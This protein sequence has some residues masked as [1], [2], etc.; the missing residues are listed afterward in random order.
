[1]PWCKIRII[2][3]TDLSAYPGWCKAVLIDYY[4]K[5]H[6]IIEKLPVCGVDY[7]ESLC[8][9]CDGYIRCSILNEHADFI[10]ISTRTPDFIE[11]TDGI[12]RFTVNKALISHISDHYS[13]F[14]PTKLDEINIFNDNVDVCVTTDD[15]R[16]YTF[17][18]ATKENL[19]QYPDLIALIVEKLTIENITACIDSIMR[20]DLQ[21]IEHYGT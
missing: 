13:L 20:N 2:E 19:K 7:S 9:P 5:E 3:Y 15:G 17:V 18:V 1:M 4:N 16:Q 12:D 14:L 6:I 11:S 8:L 10:E 21:T